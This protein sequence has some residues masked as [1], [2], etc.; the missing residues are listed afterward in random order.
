MYLIYLRLCVTTRATKIYYWRK[1]KSFMLTCARSSSLISNNFT[2]IFWKSS[3]MEPGFIDSKDL[4]AGKEPLAPTNCQPTVRPPYYC[5]Q[6]PISI[7]RAGRDFSFSLFFPFSVFF[8][9]LP[10]SLPQ[11]WSV[12]GLPTNP[13]WTSS[14]RIASSD[15]PPC[16][17]A[18]T[19]E[20][21][22]TRFCVWSVSCEKSNILHTSI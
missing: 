1:L 16:G 3:T 18:R 5:T 7:A 6:P 14:Y 22:P 20:A 15:C 12:V 8:F 19:L 13:E 4:A 2:F 9:S 21:I 17:H 10:F 11:A